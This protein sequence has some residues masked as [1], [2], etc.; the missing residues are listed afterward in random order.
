M[1][2]RA[3]LIG[4]CQG[5]WLAAIYAALHPE[6]VH[7]L[8]LA[9]A[10]IDFH[11]GESVIAA[12]TR[13]LT[14]SFGLAPYRALVAAGGGNMPGRAVLGQLH[15]HP[16]ARRRSR[17]SCSCWSTSTTTPT[18]RATAAFED[19][20]KHTQDIP[21]AF[22]LWLV[23]HLFWGNELISRPAGDR[24]PA[25]RARRD[26]TARCSCSPG[27][28]TTSPRPSRCSRPA[29]AVGTPRPATSSGGS[30]TP[31]ISGCS[32]AGTRCATDW[33]PLMLRWPRGPRPAPGPRGSGIS[34]DGRPDA[35]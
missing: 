22:Y 24:R 31:A 3:N 15:R 21:G 2:G 25:G 29:D 6:R 14:S 35:G 1:G 9:G 10:P 17:A 26:P 16:A 13:A 34:R 18:S 11:A 33:P 30:P 27:P 4:D 12:S 23:E 7:T 19:W 5:G 28:A 8:T 32:W 20:F